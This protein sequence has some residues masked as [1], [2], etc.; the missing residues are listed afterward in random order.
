MSTTSFLRM[1]LRY[2][3]AAKKAAE[4]APRFGPFVMW[5]SL[6]CAY[7]PARSGEADL[8]DHWG[9]GRLPSWWWGLLGSGHAL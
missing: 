6:A 5:D 3:A 8:T 4:V 9:W 1:W 7:W 2:E